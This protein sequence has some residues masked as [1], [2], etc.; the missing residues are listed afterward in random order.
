MGAPMLLWNILQLKKYGV[1]DF[2]LTLH[3]LPDVIM[4]YFGD[5][6]RFGVTMSYHIEPRP[7]GSGGGMKVF[8]DRLDNDFFYLYGDIFSMVDYGAMRAAFEKKKDAVGMQRVQ[9]IEDYTDADAVELDQNGKFIAIHPKPHT[10]TYPNAYRMRGIFIMTKKTFPHVPRAAYC[11][12]GK[13]LLPDVIQHGEKF[14]AYECDDYSKGIDTKE[15]WHEVEEYLREN[16]ID[17]EPWS[18]MAL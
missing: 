7:S 16:H 13:D 5:G 12:I 10:S 1:T 6:S 18:K 14:Y 9:K 15:K 11:E 4:D 8:E 2:F 3:Y 17:F